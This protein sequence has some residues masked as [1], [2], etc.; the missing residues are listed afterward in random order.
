MG[1][2]NRTAGQQFVALLLILL[3]EL[4]RQ[5]FKECLVRER[6]R[7]AI[8]SWLGAK[9]FHLLVVLNVVIVFLIVICLGRLHHFVV[10]IY[11]LLLIWIIKLFVL[12]TRGRGSANTFKWRHHKCCH[13]GS[14]LFSFLVPTPLIDLGLAQPRL[15]RHVKQSL[16]RPFWVSFKLSHKRLKLVTRLALPLSNDSFTVTVIT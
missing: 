4:V 8:E 6:G 9:T 2:A 3:S 16:F 1:I 7:V 5:L 13:L 11:L 12:S 14:I 10:V 15:F